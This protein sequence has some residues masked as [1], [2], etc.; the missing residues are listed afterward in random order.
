M[1]RRAEPLHPYSTP[2][3]SAG[4]DPRTVWEQRVREPRRLQQLRHSGAADITA[5][6][7][8]TGLDALT[9]WRGRVQRAPS[10]A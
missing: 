9:A 6:P 1:D 7:I 4:W 5:A 8:A 3:D 10:R 2:A